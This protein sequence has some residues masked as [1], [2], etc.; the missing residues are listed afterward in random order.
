M[1]RLLGVA[2]ALLL[3]RQPAQATDISI[4]V[5]ENS[6]HP[7]IIRVRGQLMPADHLK[8]VTAFSALAGYQK[9]AIVFLDSPGGAT[10]TAVEIGLIINRR[11]FSTAVADHTLCTSSC[12]L[13]WLGG[14]E[15]F[16]GRYARI[17]FHAAREG[18]TFEV[19][20]TGNA[21]AGAY[22]SQVGIT[23]FAT[24]T[25]LTKARPDALTWLNPSDAGRPPI[26]TFKL[27]SFSE[28]QWAW[29][30]GWAQQR[31]STQR[32]PAGV[33]TTI[34][35]TGRVIR[36]PLTGGASD[37]VPTAWQPPKPIVLPIVPPVPQ[38]RF[39]RFEDS[40]ETPDADTAQK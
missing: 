11:G 26:P 35:V 4:A 31:P 10:R 25:F 7:A 1:K 21:I 39:R 30:E 22:L 19:S 20:S 38:V 33:A 29:A 9:S 36:I 12:A 37:A 40:A 28:Q 17:G 32:D 13:V 8:D 27:F 5:E 2:I 24:I 6:D 15:R 14:K 18:N 16:M 34:G 23:D 3:G